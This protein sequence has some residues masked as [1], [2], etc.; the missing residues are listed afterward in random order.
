MNALELQETNNELPLYL[1]YAFLSA[2]L[3]Q[4]G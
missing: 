3:D 2:G 4:L 1:R